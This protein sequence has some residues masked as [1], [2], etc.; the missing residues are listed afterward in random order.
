MDTTG[1]F[2]P[3]GRRTGAPSPTT[4]GIGMLRFIEGHDLIDQYKKLVANQSTAS[5]AVAFWGKGAAS[6]FKITKATD[7]RMIL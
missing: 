6:K 5:L 4:G 2:A 1:R 3:Y 7:I